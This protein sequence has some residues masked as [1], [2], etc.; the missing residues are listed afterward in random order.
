MLSAH[1]VC[2]PELG[3]T[4]NFET[5]NPGCIVTFSSQLDSGNL[6]NVEQDDDDKVSTRTCVASQRT[7]AC[8]RKH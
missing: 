8:Q 6:H 5:E 2:P 7:A 3:Q 4:W 1:P